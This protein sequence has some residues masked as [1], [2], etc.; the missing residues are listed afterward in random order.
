[1]HNA[2]ARIPSRC[3]VAEHFG[4]RDVASELG[5]AGHAAHAAAAPQTTANGDATPGEARTAAPAA[6][7]AVQPSSNGAH[8][9]RTAAPGSPPPRRSFEEP[10]AH[11]ISGLSSAS[12]SPS[13]SMRALAARATSTA[14]AAGDDGSLGHRWSVGGAAAAPQPAAAGPGP[15]GS[16]GGAAWQAGGGGAAGEQGLQQGGAARGSPAEALR[17]SQSGRGLRVPNLY[18]LLAA[19]QAEDAGTERAGA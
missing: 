14:A 5:A 11:A 6:R 8:H 2:T 19:K 18:A 9:E 7:A 12:P 1:M 4:L 16:A 15:A 13:P 3:Q 10:L 17:A